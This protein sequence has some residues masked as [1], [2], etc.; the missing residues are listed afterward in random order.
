[1]FVWRN[2]FW[3]PWKRSEKSDERRWLKQKWHVE[4]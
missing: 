2:D 1:M 3:L 4:Y